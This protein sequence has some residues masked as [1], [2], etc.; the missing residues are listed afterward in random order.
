[1]NDRNSFALRDDF[2]FVPDRAIE[3]LMMTFLIECTRAHR[4]FLRVSA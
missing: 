1:M 3:V 2:E 4:G